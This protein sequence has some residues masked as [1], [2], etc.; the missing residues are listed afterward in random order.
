MT[1]D[2]HPRRLDAVLDPTYLDESLDSRTLS[3]ENPTGA[4]GA[5]G[6]T[7]GGRKGRG[8]QTFPAGTS[9]VI[10][11]IEGPGTLRH[12][13]I[14]L[15][16]WWA[17]PA[18][19]RSLRLEG[20]YDG[21]GE[22]S[23]SVPLLDFFGNPHG[24]VAEHYSQLTTAPNGRGLN[25]YVPIPFARSIRIELVNESDRD[26]DIAFQIDYTLEPGG[27]PPTSFLHVSFRRENPT[28]L[29]RD[30][31]IADGFTGP[32]RFLGC[33]VGIRPLDTSTFYGEGEQKIYRDGDREFPTI[34]GTGL[35]DYLGSAFGIARHHGP[36]T[37]APLVLFP[38]G[39]DDD[40]MRTPDYLTFYRWHLPDPVMFSTEIRV[41][42][43]Q[44]GITPPAFET[45]A[46]ADEYARTHLPAYRG[47]ARSSDGMGIYGL[48]EREDDYCAT[49]FVYCRTPQ[50]VP[51]YDVESARADL[52]LLPY[53]DPIRLPGHGGAPVDEAAS[54]EMQ[55]LWRD[56]PLVAVTRPFSPASRTSSGGTV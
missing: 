3:S 12:F 14:A 2:Q 48:A 1:S 36:Y 45:A 10:A 17:S 52:D 25:S 32:G 23:I 49:A 4:R 42:L 51:R 35:E 50:P 6:M 56:D 28:T 9:T 38:P 13:W 34:C 21:M 41:T 37:G 29:R 47:W 16:M 43:Q 33:V 40:A 26:A 18:S 22:P 24:R 53:E 8:G 20:Y 11:D 7:F 46:E 5:G 39:A 19:M 55:R 15:P 30:F 44:I 27:P 54:A 31:V